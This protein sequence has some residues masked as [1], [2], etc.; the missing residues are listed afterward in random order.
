MQ[1]TARQYLGTLIRSLLL[2]ARQ[3]LGTMNEHTPPWQ[4]QKQLNLAGIR[5]GRAMLP[6]LR[7]AGLKSLAGGKLAQDTLTDLGRML[8]ID[9]A[10]YRCS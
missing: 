9:A 1:L 8:L 3:S 6:G 4:S 7:G 5:L 2:T 10:K